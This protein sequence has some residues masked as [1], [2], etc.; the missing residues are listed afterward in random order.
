VAPRSERGESIE[1]AM[2]S[3]PTSQYFGRTRSAS[4]AAGDQRYAP[5]GTNDKG[6]K[7]LVT[8]VEL[9]AAKISLDRALRVTLGPKVPLPVTVKVEPLPPTALNEVELG[10]TPTTG[11]ERDGEKSGGV[12]PSQ[13]QP[14]PP[15][16]PRWTREGME[17][18]SLD[19]SATE[20][21]EEVDVVNITEEEDERKGKVP[22]ARLRPVCE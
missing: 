8:K 3:Q 15:D 6:P 17:V 20:I 10:S 14:N 2:A 18:D 19:G 13:P 12:T 1:E 9:V 16:Q 4:R 11:G 5:Y 7:P 21:D 22:E